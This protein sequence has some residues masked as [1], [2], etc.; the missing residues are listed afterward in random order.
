MAGA[1][2]AVRAHLSGRVQ[3]VWFR[4]SCAARARAAQVDGWA[5]N[6]SDGTVEVWLEGDREAVGRV[7]D[8]CRTGPPRAA[9]SGVEVHEEAPAGVSGFRVAGASAG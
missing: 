2:I 1:R 3:G 4:Q 9:V 5:R 8:W 6:L 7:L